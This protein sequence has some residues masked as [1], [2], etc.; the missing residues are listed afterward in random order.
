MP[1]WLTCSDC[2]VSYWLAY[3]LIDLYWLPVMLTDWLIFQ[4]WWIQSRLWLVKSS[5]QVCHAQ[6]HDQT[7]A[8]VCTHT[9]AHTTHTHTHTHTPSCCV[10]KGGSLFACFHCF[11]VAV[12][13]WCFGQRGVQPVHEPELHAALPG[14]FLVRRPLQ[15]HEPL[16]PESHR[17]L[18]RSTDPQCKLCRS[19]WRSTA[20]RS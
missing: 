17:L 6:I 1:L 20:V 7:H 10:M 13:V 11:S 16:W 14:V 8:R 18:P 9:H 4:S 5:V 2:S 3:Q 12:Q 19:W 15:L